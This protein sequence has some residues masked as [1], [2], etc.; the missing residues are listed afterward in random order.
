MSE[1]WVF[2]SAAWDHVYEFGR[3]PGPGERV[4]ARRLGRRAGGST[5]NVA[6]ALG[7]AGHRVHLVTRVGT[8]A[9]GTELLTEL[10][11]WP[12]RTDSV[13]REG[14][15]TPETLVF[16]DENAEPTIVIVA[17]EWDARVPVPYTMIERADGVYVGRYSDYDP[18]LPAFLSA[19]TAL[20]MTAVPPP[21]PKTAWFA[22]VVIGS[23]DEY[24]ESWLA[25]PY[26]ALHAVIGDPLRWVIVTRGAEGATAHGRNGTVGIPVCE[27]V[28]TDATGAGDSF[29]AGLLHGLLAGRDLATAGRLGARWASATVAR[30]QSVP[31]RW[32]ELGL[33]TPE[34][35]WV[36]R[37]SNPGNED[38]RQRHAR[39]P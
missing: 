10:A 3:M 16:R 15:S 17:E 21:E 5:A 8:D 37:L 7:S 33:G 13:L 32:D 28:V 23:R 1:V 34:A 4:I 39:K 24:P 9:L 26:D 27:V 20:V 36:E 14:D 22:H 6:R 12:V 11:T 35:D 2:G 19:R 31:A 38:W 29:A 18:E 25:A 30:S